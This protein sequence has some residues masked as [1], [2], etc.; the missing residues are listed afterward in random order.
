MIQ[1]INISLYWDRKGTIALNLLKGLIETLD[2]ESKRK[3]DKV[4]QDILLLEVTDNY[5]NRDVEKHYS[6]ICTF[7]M[8]TYLSE[9]NVGIIDAVTLP[10]KKK[11]KRRTKGYPEKLSARL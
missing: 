2:E 1:R 4:Y 9:V 5:V 11:P 8:S 7:L 10:T 6:K 3:L